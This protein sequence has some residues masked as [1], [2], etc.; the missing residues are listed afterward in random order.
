MATVVLA[1]SKQEKVGRI[2]AGNEVLHVGRCHGA[3]TTRMRQ[4]M[5]QP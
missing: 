3:P 5:I 2:A 4:M 1:E